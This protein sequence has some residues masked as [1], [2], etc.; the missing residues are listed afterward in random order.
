M[1]NTQYHIVSYHTG[2][3]AIGN[4]QENFL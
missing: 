1:L 4:R 3:V 2:N